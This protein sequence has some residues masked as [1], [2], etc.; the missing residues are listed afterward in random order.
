MGGCLF[1]GV[2]RSAERLHQP[3]GDS[4]FSVGPQHGQGSDGR[5]GVLGDAVRI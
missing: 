4:K 3:G 5:N 1:L 2:R